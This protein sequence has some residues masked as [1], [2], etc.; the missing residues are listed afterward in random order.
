MIVCA[1]CKNTFTRE[2]LDKANEKII[3]QQINTIVEK[4]ILPD[5]AKQLKSNLQKAFKGNPNI[6]IK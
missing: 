5:M 4:Q 1:N 3:K 2:Q 6:K